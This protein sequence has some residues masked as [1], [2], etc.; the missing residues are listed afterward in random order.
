MSSVLSPTDSVPTRNAATN[1]SAP[2][3]MG[4][5]V[6]IAKITTSAR[7]VTIS[8]DTRSS[9]GDGGL[10]GHPV[11]R[12]SGPATGAGGTVSRTTATACREVIVS[13]PGEPRGVSRCLHPLRPSPRLYERVVRP[14]VV[15][16]GARGRAGGTGRHRAIAE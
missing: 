9:Y 7:M 16:A 14:R 12:T 1:A 11:R 5:N 10:G 8:G 4:R 13:A 3:L 6:A 15:G 2:M